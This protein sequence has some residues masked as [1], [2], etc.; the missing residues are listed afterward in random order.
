MECGATMSDMLKMIM[1]LAPY[2]RVFCSSDYDDAIAYLEKMLPYKIHSYLA[3]DEYN[4][5]TIHPQWDL[6]QARIMKDGKV[7]FDG[8]SNALSVIALSANFKGAVDL[9][10]LKRHLFYDH[11]RDDIIPFNFRQMYQCWKRDWGFCVTKTFY[12]S[13]EPGVYDVVIDA[14]EHAGVLKVMEHTH[15]GT[16]E[17]AFAFVAHLDHPGM[18]N[19]DLAGC[20]VGVELFKKLSKIKTKFTYKLF[21]VQEIIGSEYYWGRTNCGNREKILEGLFLEMLGTET[22]LALQESGEGDSNIELALAET[23]DELCV[24]YRTGPYK[25]IIG[26]DEYVWEA[27]G[28][29]MA[30]FSRYPYPEY[31]S[32]LDNAGIISQRALDETLN[33]LMKT[34]LHLELTEL[35]VKKFQGNI[36]LSNPKY[37]LYIDPGQSAFGTDNDEQATKMRALMDLIPQLK[38]PT[39]IRAIA[40]KTG[41]DVEQVRLYLQKWCE[42]GLLEII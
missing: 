21:L 26:N 34:I 16:H 38:K 10:E 40:S 14:E 35:V 13:L 42:K 7:I 17:T 36:C 8:M 22:Q 19:D 2:R 25:S 20:A 29:P 31:H 27:Y 15:P 12:D 39:S 11:R 41:V 4:G 37:D 6:K 5:W 32:S 28:V 3:E 9:E 23:M 33:I 30:S 24:D 18:A 1:D